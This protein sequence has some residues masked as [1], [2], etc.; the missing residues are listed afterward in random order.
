MQFTCPVCREV[1][2]IDLDVL[3]QAPPPYEVR[4]FA[5]EFQPDDKF[6]TWKKEMEEA[7]EKQKAKGGI[8]D[9]EA[10]DNRFLV[11]TDVPPNIS[12]GELSSSPSSDD[13]PQQLEPPHPQ[14]AKD[15]RSDAKPALGSS[16]P[17]HRPPRTHKNY[18]H[19]HRH[20]HDQDYRQQHGQKRLPNHNRPH[21]YPPQSSQERPYGQEK[22]K[23]EPLQQGKPE[24]QQ[25]VQT[26][27]PIQKMDTKEVQ[28]R[29]LERLPIQPQQ[30][31]SNH[32]QHDQLPRQR[33]HRFRRDYVGSTG[34]K[35]ERLHCQRETN[36]NGRSEAKEGL[37]VSNRPSFQ[38][39]TNVH[40]E[41]SAA[42]GQSLPQ[43]RPPASFTT[44]YVSCILSFKS[45]HN[46]CSDR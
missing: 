2:N 38:E 42:T 44:R 37:T 30:A 11:V 13:Q 24:R 19:N 16:N 6:K 41:Q 7:Y 32:A 26:P 35:Q 39:E 8:I 33:N 40:T 10:D 17:H 20:H 21:D 27:K 43:S 45:S 4:S 3:K 5:E 22:P 18:H 36:S 34:Q 28:E 1:I 12:S 46:F 23:R 29:E 31:Q 9:R 25:T 14:Q 15:L